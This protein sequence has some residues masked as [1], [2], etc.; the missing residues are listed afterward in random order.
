MKWSSVAS[1]IIS[2][3]ATPIRSIT[4]FR[5]TP[6]FDGEP[7]A[8]FADLTAAQPTEYAA[9]IDT[10]RFALC[11][12][13][14]E[15]FFQLDGERLTAKPMKGTAARGRTLAEDEARIAELRQSEKNRAENLMIVD[16]MR[17]DLGRMAEVGSVAVPRLFEVERYPTLLQMTSTVTARTDCLRGG[18]SGEPVPL[19]VD[20]RRSQG[21]QYGNHPGTGAATAR[22][23]YRRHRFYRPGATSAVQRRHSHGADRPRTGTGDRMAWAAAWCGIRMR[24]ANTRNVCSKRAS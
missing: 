10:G 24:A 23:L 7:W 13:S 22:R 2:L 15:L 20:H 14:P 16:M 9:F 17:N 1:R 19:R 21:A 6:T 11:S 12:A 4:P 8:F 3:A 18:D 5:C